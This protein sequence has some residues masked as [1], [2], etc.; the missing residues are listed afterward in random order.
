MLCFV[1]CSRQKLFNIRLSCVGGFWV[2]CFSITR[3][4]VMLEISWEKRQHLIL[5]HLQDES[6]VGFFLCVHLRI[7]KKRLNTQQSRKKSKSRI[8]FVKPTLNSTC[9]FDW[10][11]YQKAEWNWKWETRSSCVEWKW[12]QLGLHST[13]SV[14]QNLI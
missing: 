1:F 6:H 13:L 7:K 10:I 14:S 4:A 3:N 8:F 2:F 12:I 11:T 5:H 9:Q